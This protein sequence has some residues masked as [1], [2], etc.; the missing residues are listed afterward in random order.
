MNFN[1]LKNMQNQII[2]AKIVNELS[3]VID[4]L[5]LLQ[6]NQ[7]YNRFTNNV[8][9]HPSHYSTWNNKQK[10]T[11]ILPRKVY[12]KL[13]HARKKVKTIGANEVRAKHLPQINVTYQF[14]Y[15]A[16]QIFVINSDLNRKSKIKIRIYPSILLYSDNKNSYQMRIQTSRFQTKISSN[17]YKETFCGLFSNQQ[18]MGR[19]QI[20]QQVSPLNGLLNTLDPHQSEPHQSE[21]QSVRIFGSDK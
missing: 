14:Y 4:N 1:N 8:Q 19:L 21:L 20:S 7:K 2:R 16:V 11:H 3:D 15:I 17:T 18:P 6:I 10:H 12:K 13:P 9:A 5:F